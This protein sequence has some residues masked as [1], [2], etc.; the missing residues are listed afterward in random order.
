M[1]AYLAGSIVLFVVRISTALAFAVAAIAALAQNPQQTPPIRVST[2]L[3]QIGVIV[4]DSHGP[5][6]DLTKDDFVLLDRGKAQTI[7][8]FNVESTASTSQTVPMQPLT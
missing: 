3:V 5:V 1:T 8:V 2:H 4:R 7:S 6:G